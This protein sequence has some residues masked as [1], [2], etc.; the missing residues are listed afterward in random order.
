MENLTFQGRFIIL[1]EMKQTKQIYNKGLN[2]R[3]ILKYGLYA[4]ILAKL[5]PCLWLSGCG[6]WG[7]RKKDNRCNIVLIS[8]DTLRRD[9]CSAYGYARDTTPSLSG[10]ARQATSF[11]LAYSPTSTTGPTHASLFTGLY[12]IAHRVLKNGLQLSKEHETLAE[13]LKAEDYQTAAIV[14][15]FVLDAKF[16]YAQG[17]AYY[18]D[19]FEFSQS[20]I[21]PTQW[22][23]HRVDGAFDRRADYA[24]DR[25]IGWLKNHRRSNQPFFL[26]VHYFDPHDPYTPPQPFADR[27]VPPNAPAKSLKSYIGRYDDEIAFTD[28]QLGNLLDA[29]KQMA[30]EEQTLVVILSD[31][32]EGLMNHG[33]MYHGVHIYEEAVRVPL[34]FRWPNR[35]PS[36]RVLSAPV[37]LISFT[38][39][40]LDLVN[41]ESDRRSFQSHSLAA[42]LRGETGLD[43]QQPIYLYRRYYK[44]GK[45]GKI[46]V[47]GD[48]FGIRTGP[49][50]YIEGKEEKTKELFDLAADP[51]ERRN[52]CG[53][54]PEKA[55]QLASQLAKWKQRHGR[56]VFGQGTISK[57][58]LERLKTLGYV[59]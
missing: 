14:S 50:K 17:F 47:K 1:L 22:E 33:H 16:G 4:G 38:P 34:L 26:F 37:G 25:A 2:R 3:N 10:F 27:F 36:G 49:W 28:Q 7:G 24:T 15:S 32:G 6:K 59:E 11:D 8:I 55:T 52:L 41:I 48:K 54:F 42:S 53:K 46:A 9:H 5:Q 18:D 51:K 39:T 44:T 56:K 57:E 21:S 43:P 20:T 30:L 23:G 40:I 19:D 13:I 58:D 31:H 12:P 45:I 35:I 29:L